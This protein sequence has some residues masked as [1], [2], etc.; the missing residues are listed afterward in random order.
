MVPR[1]RFLRL[2]VGAVAATPI[3]FL[4]WLG[5]LTFGDSLGVE[6]PVPR[7]ST[8]NVIFLGLAVLAPLH[9][10]VL[11]WL[12]Y[13]IAPHRWP[14]DARRILWTVAL[15]WFYPLVAVFAWYTFMWRAPMGVDDAA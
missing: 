12:L 4:L 9:L 10:G 13:V 8:F 15:L 7:H 6:L 11:G 1:S 2:L 14:N 5:V 3:V